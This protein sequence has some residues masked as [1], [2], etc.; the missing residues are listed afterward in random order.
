[1]SSRI[2]VW[3]LCELLYTCYLLV[4]RLPLDRLSSEDSRTVCGRTNTG[5]HSTRCSSRDKRVRLP[6]SRYTAQFLSRDAMLARCM[7]SSYVRPSVRHKSVL[8]RNDESSWFWARRLPSIYPTLCCKEILV[9]PNIRVLPCG[10]LSNTP[11]L[12]TISPRWTYR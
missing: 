7:L 9:S 3:Q 1:V 4:T 10:T 8:Y 12:E 5:L 2:A 11:D 6:L